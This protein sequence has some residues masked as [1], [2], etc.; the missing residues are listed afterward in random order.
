MN[1]RARWITDVP[2]RYTEQD[3]VSKYLTVAQVSQRTGFSPHTI[4]DLLSRDVIS[5]PN[6]PLSALSRP[7][8]RVGVAPYYSVEQVEK[9]L[10]LKAN[11]KDKPQ[12]GE[13]VEPPKVTVEEAHERGLI[14]M[15]EIAE[16]AEVHEQTVRKWSS[17][18]SNFPQPVARRERDPGSHSGVPFVVYEKA[19]VLEW[20][21]EWKARKVSTR[22]V[23]KSVASATARAKQRNTATV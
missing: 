3:K 23:R 17:R 13:W 14:S 11:A 2:D 15:V 16:L 1:T 8:A 7:A 12:G 10:A 21:R 4:S 6:N 22:A 20:I 18:N 5:A 19:A 9:C